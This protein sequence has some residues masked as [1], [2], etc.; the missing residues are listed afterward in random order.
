MSHLPFFF[1]FSFDSGS[2]GSLDLDNQ[3]MMAAQGALGIC[4]P[5]PSQ[6]EAHTNMPPHL[7]CLHVGPGNQTRVIVF[8]RPFIGFLSTDPFL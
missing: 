3:L 4:V 8:A 2:F 7:G 6:W 1:I 5:P